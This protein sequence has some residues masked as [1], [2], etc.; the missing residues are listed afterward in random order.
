LEKLIKKCIYKIPLNEKRK[1]FTFNDD[2]MEKQYDFFLENIDDDI[3]HEESLSKGNDSL[4]R[5]SNVKPYS[6]NLININNQKNYINASSI[7]ILKKNYFIATQGPIDKT[8]ED[9]WTMIDENECKVIVMLCNIKENGNEKCAKYWDEEKQMKKYKITIQ[10]KTEKGK[11]II[12]EIKLFNLSLKKEKIVYQIHFIAWPDHGVP[13]IEDGKI[14][15][16]FVEM[17][18]KVD[19]YRENNPIVIHCSAGVGRTGTFISMY[20]LYKEIKTQIK[21]KE[22]KIYFNIFN[23]VRKLKEMRILSVQTCIQYQFI[24][25]FVYYLLEKYNK[26]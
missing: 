7:N 25:Y 15:N 6:F 21:N 11:Y 3:K 8:V 22:E 17:I 26:R 9:F 23:L 16:V 5:Y 4:N 20:F 2:L 10:N 14:F 18:K 24:Y 12:R 13:K 19:N 1:N